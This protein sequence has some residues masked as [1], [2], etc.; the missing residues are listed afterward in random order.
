MSL[1]KHLLILT[2]LASAVCGF[3]FDEYF[4]IRKTSFTSFTL[5]GIGVD[6]SMIVKFTNMSGMAKINNLELVSNSFPRVVS[7]LPFLPY[8]TMNIYNVF[9]LDLSKSFIPEMATIPTLDITMAIVGTDVMDTDPKSYRCVVFKDSQTVVPVK[10]LSQKGNEFTF[11]VLNLERD[12]IGNNK[13]LMFGLVGKTFENVRA[14][15]DVPYTIEFKRSLNF[16]QQY[17]PMDENLKME[18][19]DIFNFPYS[20][21]LQNRQGEYSK[22]KL[23]YDDYVPLY[24]FSTKTNTSDPSFFNV[25]FSFNSNFTFYNATNG[26][27]FNIKEDT[28]SIATWVNDYW[29]PDQ[30]LVCNEQTCELTSSVISGRLVTICGVI[31]NTPPPP[32]HE[33]EDTAHGVTLR[34]NSKLYLEP[35]SNGI[36]HLY[37]ISLPAGQQVILKIPRIFGKDASTF[38]IY[39][40]FKSETPNSQ[41]YENVVEISKTMKSITISNNETLARTAYFQLFA[42]QNAINY[43]DVSAFMMP[44]SPSYSNP[45]IGSPSSNDGNII[46]EKRDFTW[47]YVSIGVVFG[48]LLLAAVITIV[49]VLVSKWRM[50]RQAAHI[51][52]PSIAMMDSSSSKYYVMRDG[53]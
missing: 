8:D 31:D 42:N 48:G 15:F 2:L 41:N 45:T 4:T 51:N 29:I 1:L 26:K 5:T 38:T 11:T 32:H 46:S 16:R 34:N 37:Q 47:L 9:Q 19:K 49:F 18:F 22:I 28:L 20:V 10:A 21:N 24:L 25:V 35:I 23:D 12:Y 43:I 27:S 53:F 7:N 17:S 30:K 36:S 40:S 39:Q 3:S 44:I 52:N 50:K 33:R 13:T 14:D 6:S